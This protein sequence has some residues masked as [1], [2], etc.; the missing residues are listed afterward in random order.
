MQNIK[1]ARRQLKAPEWHQRRAD[2]QKSAAARRGRRR[3]LYTV[4]QILFSFSV[5]V[6]R[7]ILFQVTGCD[8][9]IRRYCAAN[10]VANASILFVCTADYTV[11]VLFH[12]YYYYYGY[13]G[14]RLN[15]LSTYASSCNST[16][17]LVS[18]GSSG[19]IVSPNYP[20]GYPL[21]NDCYYLLLAGS[22]QNIRIRI[23]FELLLMQ[24]SSGCSTEYINV[25]VG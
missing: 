6:K 18:L 2:H 3:A 1:N 4:N 14:F 20:G 17:G 25:S 13:R 8:G 16:G 21:I 7:I 22:G 24:N 23:A 15:Y 5:I 12:S 9:S 19:S 10:L 11:T